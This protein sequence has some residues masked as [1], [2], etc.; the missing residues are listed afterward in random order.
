MAVDRQAIL[1][2]IS[3]GLG[4]LFNFPF[5]EDWELYTPLEELPESAREVIEYNPEKAKQLLAEAGYP[6]GFEC[7][8][9]FYG[10]TQAAR[11]QADMLQDVLADVGV[12]LEL[13]AMGDYGAYIG[14]MYSKRYDHM[15]MLNHGEGNPC[16]ILRKSFLPKQPWNP[17]DWM[18]YEFEEKF[19]TAR[20]EID[21]AKRNAALKE[22]NIYAIEQCP[23]I[24]LTV[25]DFYRYAWPWVGNFYGQGVIGAAREEDSPAA[26]AVRRGVTC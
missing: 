11:D 15:Y 5:S 12:D 21:E 4:V 14:T 23:Y 6:D 19:L 16:S 25:G 13:N 9:V 22:L 18:D 20:A 26:A 24:I 2:R 1:D 7:E 3:G 17:P 8:L 10:A